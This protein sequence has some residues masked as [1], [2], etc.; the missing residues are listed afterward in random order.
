M[1][2][3]DKRRINFVRN[4]PIDVKVSVLYEYLKM[5]TSNRDIETII[6]ALKEEDGWQAWS[7]IHFYGFDKSFKSKY[8]SLNMMTLKENLVKLNDNDLEE[9]HLGMQ[10]IDPSF[11]NIGINKNDGKDIFRM[12][13]TRQ[14]QYKLRKLLM[15]NFQC[16]CA[17]C[18]V[19]HAKLLITSHIKPWSCSSAEERINA[20][21]GILLCK[22]HDGL[23]E[24]GFIS[25]DDN[26][27]V[28]YSSHFN[29]EE[30]GLLKGLTFRRPLYDPPSYVFLREHRKKHGFE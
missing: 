17:L 22:I 13:K 2:K 15:R 8:P 19:S 29:F 3:L 27:E 26:Y 11:L 14:G 30:Q 12:I 20:T 1:A 23:F 28:L 10:Q 18:N 5:G 9:F 16:K 4:L 21:N 25:L 24:N 6:N 7:V